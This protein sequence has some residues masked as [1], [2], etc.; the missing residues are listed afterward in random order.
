MMRNGPNA[1]GSGPADLRSRRAQRNTGQLAPE[2]LEASSPPFRPE[3]P[4]NGVDIDGISLED[5]T[6]PS[7]VPYSHSSPFSNPHSSP[8]N[9]HSTPFNNPH[10]SPFNAGPRQSTGSQ[11]SAGSQRSGGNQRSPRPAFSQT[12]PRHNASQSAPRPKVDLT[13]L[14]IGVDYGT[15]FTGKRHT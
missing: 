12:T 15:T 8:F 1:T 13:R 2:H 3:S 9:T 6:Q 7:R 4:L 14:V 5:T 10:S 11:R